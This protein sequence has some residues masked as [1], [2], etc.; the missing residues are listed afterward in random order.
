MFKTESNNEYILAITVSSQALEAVLVHDTPSGPEVLT[1]F[2]RGRADATNRELDDMAPAFGDA[3]A[4]SQGVNPSLPTF[5]GQST[6]G[7]LFLSSEFGDMAGGS[8]VSM[9]FQ[10][11]SQAAVPCDLEIQDILADCKHAGYEGIQIVFILPAEYLGS[12][13][14][15]PNTALQTGSGKSRKAKKDALLKQFLSDHPDVSAEQVAFLP[16]TD[17]SGAYRKELALYAKNSEPVSTSVRAIQERKESLPVIA[18]MRTEV[19]LLCGAL[20]AVLL[21]DQRENVIAEAVGEALQQDAVAAADNEIGFAI[22]VGAENTLVMFTVGDELVHCESLRSV[23]AFDSAD[24]ICSRALLL[25]D[26]FGLEDSDRILLFA[27]EYEDHLRSSLARAFPSSRISLLRDLVPCAEDTSRASI[28]FDSILA[29]LGALS[30]V[31]DDIWRS[32]FPAIDFMDPELQPTKFALPLSWPIAAMMVI[33]FCSTLFFVYRYLDQDRQIEEARYALS[34]FPEVS[35]TEN[36][37][38]LQ[39]KID[40]LRAR[41]AGFADALDLLDSLLVGSDVWSRALERT[42]AHTGDVSGLW[43]SEWREEGT[44]TLAIR[45]RSLNR[46]DIVTFASETR[47]R[48]ENIMFS[49]I[50]SIPV[51]EFDMTLAITRKLP[52]AAEYLRK[53]AAERIKEGSLDSL[54]TSP[55]SSELSSQTTVGAGR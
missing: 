2:R 1:T 36:V 15:D 40:S 35:T 30:V 54:L 18:A 37:A 49:E 53:Q 25:H 10:W 17:F 19:T 3:N 21:Q 13:V 48:I 45:G 23:T 44:G 11:S 16:L 47:G 4:E 46:D 41:S 8:D 26:E 52:Q 7:G 42:S 50:R 6:G 32:V 24:T 28:S 31:Q 20:R 43:I 39:M 27:D 29:T 34:Q 55:G 38:D 14:L 12:E 33:L 9:D 51:Y 22:R 5:E